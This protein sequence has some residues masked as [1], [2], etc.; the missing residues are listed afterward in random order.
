MAI[1]SANQRNGCGNQGRIYTR[2]LYTESDSSKGS[3]SGKHGIRRYCKGIE[4]GNFSTF[5]GENI[6]NGFNNKNLH[7]KKN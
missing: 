6:H 4:S 5:V 1:N 3:G 2:A 7:S